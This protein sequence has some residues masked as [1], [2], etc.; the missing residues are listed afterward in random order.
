MA[1]ESFTFQD[2][3][4]SENWDLFKYPVSLPV[5]HP[6]AGFGPSHALG[7]ALVK[8]VLG[9]CTPKGWGSNFG[10]FGFPTVIPTG[11][12]KVAARRLLALL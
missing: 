11:N 7:C 5:Y 10:D 8:H 4:P 12:P 2:I 6:Q 1:I 9:F 3:C